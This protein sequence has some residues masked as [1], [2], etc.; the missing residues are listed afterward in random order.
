MT[1]DLDRGY[2]TFL[3][4]LGRHGAP[5]PSS[6]AL[7]RMTRDV[8]EHAGI[9][10]QAGTFDG[11]TGGA[12]EGACGLLGAFVALHL[13]QATAVALA[14]A[15]TSLIGPLAAVLGLAGVVVTRLSPPVI[16]ITVVIYVAYRTYEGYQCE[17]E[18][19]R[20]DAVARIRASLTRLL[21]RVEGEVTG[22][23]ERTRSMYHDLGRRTLGGL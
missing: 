7:R 6:D 9:E 20:K 15:E 11:W 21:T 14:S 22:E 13:A 19:R 12:R 4:V 23:I 17:R 3:E 16:A 18:S 5:R 8:L 2:R 1:S 10:V